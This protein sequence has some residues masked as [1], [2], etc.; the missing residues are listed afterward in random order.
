VGSVDYS[1]DFLK[2]YIRR[3]CWLP[4]CHLRNSAIRRYKDKYPVRYFTFCA[5]DAID[6]FMLAQD[7]V[8]QRS[9]KSGRLET[10]YFCEEDPQVFSTIAALIGSP[11]QGFLGRF[12]EIVLFEDNEETKGKSIFDV[13][14]D[15]SEDMRNQLKLKDANGRLRSS[16]PFDIINLDVYGAMFSIKEDN[17]ITRLLRSIIQILKWQFEAQFVD[18]NNNKE[19]FT[20]YSTE[21]VHRFRRK[22]RTDS[23]SM[24]AAIP[25]GNAQAAIPA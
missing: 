22:E 9:S 24:S 12:D 6:V 17:V 14:E 16:F 3:E 5:A 25:E 2:H 10:V 11:Q 23:I 15:Y 18:T 13:D 1:S 7:G 20:A 21:R 4:A 19:R 8:L